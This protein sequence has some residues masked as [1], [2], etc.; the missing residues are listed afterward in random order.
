M[1]DLVPDPKTDKS[2]FMDTFIDSQDKG[3]KMTFTITLPGAVYMVEGG[4]KV[5]QKAVFN[6]IDIL[7]KDE[8]IYLRSTLLNQIFFGTFLTVSLGLIFLAPLIRWLINRKRKDSL[9]KD[10][11]GVGKT[12]LIMFGMFVLFSFFL[13]TFMGHLLSSVSLGRIIYG[14]GSLF[15]F[16]IF[17]Q[18]LV[19]YLGTDSEVTKEGVFSKNYF[20]E[21]KIKFSEIKK[22]EKVKRTSF[23][24]LGKWKVSTLSGVSTHPDKLWHNGHAYRTGLLLHLKGG[25]TIYCLVRDI[26]WVFDAIKKRA[27]A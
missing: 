14:F 12:I 11:H 15:F 16:L 22:I 4:K 10:G 17:V 24:Y 18:G 2:G 25:S 13:G 9:Y 7:E 8:E 27:R 26:D 21:R 19:G 3:A 23:S 5:N 1:S 6:L 20:M